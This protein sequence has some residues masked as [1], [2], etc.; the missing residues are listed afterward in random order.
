MKNGKT[1]VGGEM[2]IGATPGP[3]ASVWLSPML[4]GLSAPVVAGL[5]LF[6]EL[7]R[8]ALGMLALVLSVALFVAI[9]AYI[10]SVL[11][12]GV[13][14]ALEVR[15]ATSEVAVVIS[16]ALAE[17]VVLVP[18]KEVARLGLIKSSDQ[19]GYEVTSV[20]LKTRDGDAWVVAGNT[21]EA[22]IVR[23]RSVIGIRPRAR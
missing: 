19:D 11:A 4:I 15:Q 23:L 6:P 18:F 12:P 21:D 14:V 2:W 22:T 3:G 10:V 9:A 5:V 16:G 17:R 8:D 20:E 13:P 7:L 1:A